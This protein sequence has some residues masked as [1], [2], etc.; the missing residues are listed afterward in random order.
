MAD[1]RKN[2]SGDAPGEEDREEVR[3]ESEKITQQELNQGS[4][5]GTHDTTRR[6]VDWG[7]SYRGKKGTGKSKKASS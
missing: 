7:A 2:L 5:T 3:R 4:D 6:G 1:K